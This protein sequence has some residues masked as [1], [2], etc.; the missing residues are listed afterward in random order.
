MKAKLLLLITVFVVIALAVGGTVVAVTIL[1]EPAVVATNALGGLVKDALERDEI[2]PFCELFTSGS[3]E[4]SLDGMKVNGYDSFGEGSISGKLYFSEDAFMLRNVK[5]NLADGDVKLNGDAYISEDVVYVNEQEILGGTYGINFSSLADDLSNSIF[6]ADSGSVYALDK[7]TYDAMIKRLDNVSENKMMQ[8]DL[9]KLSRRVFLDL[10]E[11]VLDHAE[12]S[13]E[14][15][16][17]DLNGKSTKVR[18]ISITIDSLAMQN[19]IRDAYEYLCDS[20]EIVAFIEKHENT[21]YGALEAL[22]PYD[23]DANG[24]L[25]ELYKKKM[26]ELSDTVEDLCNELE[27]D[28]SSALSIHIAT[29]RIS[30]KLLKLWVGDDQKTVLSIDCGKKGMRKTDVITI[31]AGEVKIVYKVDKKGIKKLGASIAIESHNQEIEFSVSIDKKEGTYTA[32]FKHVKNE[33]NYYLTEWVASG[34]IATKRSAITFTIDK[35]NYKHRI[36]NSSDW[37]NRYELECEVIVKLED[38]M[39]M[40]RKVYKTVADITEEDIE[41]FVKKLKKLVS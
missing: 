2:E 11:I 33:K 37:W 10:W 40:P 13:S 35:V 31:E 28:S 27:P 32:N 26:S 24:S 38:E 41:N 8:R 29:S 7:E 3:I 22:Y 39:P 17:I 6:A 25:A 18:L 34:N 5:V 15:V 23:W 20:E 14:V 4:A 30:G 12:L 1:K 9:E 16:E 36:N 21:L 19:I